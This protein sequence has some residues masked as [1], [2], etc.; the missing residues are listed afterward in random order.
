MSK[1][2]SDDKPD[3]SFGAALQDRD[4]GLGDTTELGVEEVDLLAVRLA[5]RDRPGDDPARLGG[6]HRGGRI[7]G[8][9]L[10]ARRTADRETRRSRASRLNRGV[11]L[12]DLDEFGARSGA[13]GEES[14]DGNDRGRRNELAHYPH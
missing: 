14:G 6:G 13:E 12:A 3:V 7:P 5:Q 8:P 2:K 10:E 4:L 11:E 9:R 1:S